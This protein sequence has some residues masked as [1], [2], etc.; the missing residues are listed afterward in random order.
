[1]KRKN[2]KVAIIGHSGMGGLALVDQLI[3]RGIPLPVF[4]LMLIVWM[5]DQG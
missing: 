1:M 5:N 4:Q 3:A 2:M